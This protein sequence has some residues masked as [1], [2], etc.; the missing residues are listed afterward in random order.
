MPHILPKTYLKIANKLCI[1]GRYGRYQKV[2]GGKHTFYGRHTLKRNL[3]LRHYTR[4]TEYHDEKLRYSK[5]M[6]L[7]DA[8]GI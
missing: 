1:F 4:N 5:F 2:I 8:Y 7:I 3:L 6:T